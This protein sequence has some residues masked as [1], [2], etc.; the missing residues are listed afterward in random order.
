MIKLLYYQGY[1][2]RNIEYRRYFFSLG[3]SIA[4]TFEKNIGRGIADTFYRYFFLYYIGFKDLPQFA[5]VECLFTLEGKIFA[6]FLTRL[7]SI[8]FE[9]VMFFHTSIW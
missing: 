9:I 2:Y 8:H 7:S 3:E 6:P 4:N 1:Y 5:A